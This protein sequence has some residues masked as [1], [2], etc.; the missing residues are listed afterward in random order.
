[1]KKFTLGLVALLSFM[2]LNPIP[3][4]ANTVCTGS[5]CVVS[6]QY[7]G[8]QQQ[9]SVPAGATNIRFFVYGASGAR[10][11]GGGSVTGVLN[12]L[13]SIL[14][15]YVG[16]QGSQG[17]NASGG[18]NGGGDAG[19]NRGNEGSGG[20]ASDIR[21]AHALSSRIVVAGG[22]GG[23]GGY[24]GAAGAAGGGLEAAAGGSGQGGGGGGG[25][26]VSGGGAGYSNG[27][28][29]GTAGTLG[30]GGTGG[31]SWN[32][33]GG[34]GGG[35][36]Y[37]GGGG[38][39][40]DNDCCADGG[41]GGGGSSYANSSFTQ[42]VAHAAGVNSGHG[43]IEIHYTLIPVVTSFTGAQAS[44]VSATFTLVVSEA[45]TNLDQGDFLVSGCSWR[46]QTILG[47]SAVISLTSCSHGSI[48]LTL[49]DS[50]IGA[51]QNGP[52]QPVAAT[53][54]FD[55]QAPTF[56]WQE[57]GTVFSQSS[58][59]VGFSVQEA[60]ISSIAQFDLGGCQGELLNLA[61][62][63]FGCPDGARTISFG[64]NQLS[65]SWGNT[66]PASAVSYQVVFDQTAPVATWSDVQIS[67]TGT[68][69]YSAIINFSESVSFSV[70]S[71]VFTSSMS[72]VRGESERESG[73]FFWAECGYGS[74]SWLLTALSL[75]DAVG[76][77]GPIEPVSISFENSA[78]QP[79]AIQTESPSVTPPTQSESPVVTTPPQEQNPQPQPTQ[80]PVSEPVTQPPVAD[81]PQP[82]VVS[83]PAPVEVV[84]EIPAT[85][86]PVV[87]EVPTG[88]EEIDMPPI[89]FDE[90]PIFTTQD[91]SE[92]QTIDQS[93]RS[94][95]ISQPEKTEPVSESPV[96]IEPPV[97]REPIQL[98][99]NEFTFSK[100]QEF[101]ILP[102]ALVSLVLLALLGLVVIRISGR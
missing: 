99:A 101:P 66:G 85:E 76:N 77:F 2:F 52:P 24:S 9:W 15:L 96:L 14:Y 54:Q 102:V 8:T 13:P 81:T 32:A 18:Y 17:R 25:T 42:N 19:G 23:G 92:E 48:S 63:L 78:P 70:S 36:F 37:G 80:P 38:G 51:Q 100:E 34:G 31:I 69:S 46:Q 47:N 89:S 40:D 50:S 20:G 5:D 4:S 26:Q 61:V 41:G 97:E 35:G 74:A 67:G 87:E 98:A 83:E 56:T 11:G 1:M 22:G 57:S 29:S 72:C 33:G 45:I 55:G 94:P 79:A 53:I 16:G 82:P 75:M 60:T 59:V 44:S 27:G 39:A 3:A 71:V 90:V 86:S 62:R 93:P 91:I 73:W 43:R 12:N 88:S 10:G 28:S 7:T 95:K 6:F 49:K 58:V 30:Q 65:D 64:A 84:V 68:F 21:S